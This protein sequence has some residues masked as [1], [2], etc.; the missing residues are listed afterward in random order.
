[1]QNNAQTTKTNEDQETKRRRNPARSA[2]RSGCAEPKGTSAACENDA[3]VETVW[4]NTADYSGI[5]HLAG[6]RFNA[7]TQVG[8][9]MPRAQAENQGYHLAQ[10]GQ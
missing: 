8:Q 2:A 6:R 9:Y 1:M 4:V 10:N 3:A 5:Y 7:K